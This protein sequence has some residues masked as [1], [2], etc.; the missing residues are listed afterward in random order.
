MKKI[1]IAAIAASGLMTSVA[2]SATGVCER[3][4]ATCTVAA[5]ADGYF[6]SGFTARISDGV[7]LN[8]TDNTA[9]V[10]VSANHLRG[11]TGIAATGNTDGGGVKLGASAS[12]GGDAS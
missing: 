1:M 3:N 6:A 2:F 4:S 5:D 8:Y 9:N 11:T 12:G 7:E 10:A